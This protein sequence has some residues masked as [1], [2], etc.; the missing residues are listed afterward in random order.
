MMGR[1]LLLLLD[2][3]YDKISS[4]NVEREMD[5]IPDAEVLKHLCRLNVKLHGHGRHETSYFIV[6]ECNLCPVLIDAHH[7]PSAR[8]IF[9]TLL[10]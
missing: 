6:L 2:P 4:V 3:R 7:R 10:S 1:F 5:F 9:S 8:V